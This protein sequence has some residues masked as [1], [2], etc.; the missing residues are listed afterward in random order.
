MHNIYYDIIKNNVLYINGDIMSQIEINPTSYDRI[1]LVAKITNERND[2]IESIDIIGVKKYGSF[3][4]RILKALGYASELHAG[5]ETYY[6]NTNSI[7]KHVLES[8]ITKH[9]LKSYAIKD[10][11][12]TYVTNVRKGY[13]KIDTHTF[14]NEKI[15][16]IYTNVYL[17]WKLLA[18]DVEINPIKP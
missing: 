4:G 9:N 10:D 11:F 8:W 17:P 12:D 16:R 7:I 2:R 18:R 1:N 14:D 3:V 15:S 5:N 6:V 13:K